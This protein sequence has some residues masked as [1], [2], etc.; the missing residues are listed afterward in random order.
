MASPLL[1]TE[2]KM[3]ERLIITLGIIVGGIGVFFTNWILII[4]GVLAVIGF[5]Y[6]FLHP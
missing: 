2:L 1:W 6:W 3:G 5:W 4:V